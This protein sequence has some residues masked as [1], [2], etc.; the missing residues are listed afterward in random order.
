MVDDEGT[1]A[2]WIAA[3][4]GGALFDS[5]IYC[6]GAA[7][8]GNFS[9]KALG[10]AALV[11]AVTGVTFGAIGKGIKIA[12][13]A[14]KASKALNAIKVTKV[15]AISKAIAQPI[16]KVAGKIS[17][18]TKHGLA[19]VMG[20][21]GGRGVK[22]SSILDTVR[23]PVKIT[24]QENGAIK[25]VGK[26]AVVVLNEAGKVITGYAKSSKYWR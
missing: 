22:A 1:I 20:R 26:Q 9:W 21:D 8:N 16:K 6:V 18:Y 17:G 24:K 23:N 13:G 10:K 4:V 11:G 3:A 12:S 2:W 15:A 5:T 25:Y 19:Q 7:I 14:V